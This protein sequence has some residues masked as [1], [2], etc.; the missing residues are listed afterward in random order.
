MPPVTYF[1]RFRMEA[2]LARPTPVAPPLPPGFAWVAW[3]ADLADAHALAK[4]RGFAGE[5]DARLFPSLGNFDGCRALLRAIAGRPGFCPAATWLVTRRGDPAGTV[6][7]IAEGRGGAIQNLAV[8]PAFRGL[9]LGAA[10][11]AKCLEGFASVG[12]RTAALEVTAANAAA[13]GLYRR[14][15]F[16]SVQTLYKPVPVTPPD[17]PAAPA[18]PPDAAP[19]PTPL[20]AT[21]TPTA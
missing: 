18:P 9:G 5:P 2:R 10:L 12:V 3:A 14:A 21:P 6:Q 7:G 17:D 8:A 13:V 15:G 19:C 11:L 1:K 20:P 16:R 4:F